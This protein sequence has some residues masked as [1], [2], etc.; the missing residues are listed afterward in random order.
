MSAVNINNTDLELNNIVEEQIEL[1]LSSASNDKEKKAVQNL[2]AMI[3]SLFDT[4][5]TNGKS[6]PHAQT[7]AQSAQG[8][9]NSDATQPN[10]AE[11]EQAMIVLAGALA[12]MQLL[13]IQVLK[14]KGQDDAKLAQEQLA[15]LE[16][17]V[18]VVA[19]QIQKQIDAQEHESI[20]QKIAD[21]F[22]MIV[23]AILCAVGLPEIGAPM[24]VLGLLQITGALSSITNA[25]THFL[26]KDCG[27]SQT[28][29]NIVADAIVVVIVTVASMG[30]GGVAAAGETVASDAVDEGI[31]MSEMAAST[32]EDGSD[33]G[34]V[35]EDAGTTATDATS[36]GAN[37]AQ[38]A[39]SQGARMARGAVA[40]F[41]QSAMATNLVTNIVATIPFS[42]SSKGNLAKEIVEVISEIAMVIASIAASFG[43][44]AV[45]AIS[46]AGSMMSNIGKAGYLAQAGGALAS[47]AAGGYGIDAGVIQLDLAAPE[48]QTQLDETTLAMM[49]KTEQATAKFTASIQKTLQAD[50]SL[51]T[52]MFVGQEAM[53]NVMARA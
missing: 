52:K 48:S 3:T 35:A 33:V 31:E 46:Q 53:A 17:N 28:A 4:I 24:L 5:S 26:V 20:W 25:I 10:G 12:E 38:K 14:G 43:T 49:N 45:D 11:Y 41:F 42:N 30:V 9:S 27:M 36:D 23:G 34:E 44:G 6:A 51:M 2:Q 1:L 8:A 29:A 21:A 7:A 39:V 47:T 22:M 40:G 50:L 18:K 15:G 37:T 32:A 19:D 13:L 16:A